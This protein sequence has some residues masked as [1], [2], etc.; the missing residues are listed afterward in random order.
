MKYIHDLKELFD[1]RIQKTPISTKIQFK[2]QKLYFVKSYDNKLKYEEY[3]GIYNV[4]SYNTQIGAITAKADNNELYYYITKEEIDNAINVAKYNG[5]NG[6]TTK[7]Q[8]NFLK[9]GCIN[10]AIL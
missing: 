5:G 9:K 3:I 6:C 2:N 1:R 8:I 10:N 7:K 4:Y